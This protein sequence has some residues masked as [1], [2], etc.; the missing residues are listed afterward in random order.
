M[1]R[2]VTQTTQVSRSSIAAFD[3]F[4]TGQVKLFTYSGTFVVPDGITSV[5]ARC[6]GGGGAGYYNGNG[7]AGG[8]SSF[9][10]FCS[11]TGGAGGTNTS[12]WRGLGGTGSGGDINRT[13]GN[14][15]GGSGTTAGGGG[16][17]GLFANGGTGGTAANP[18]PESGNAGGGSSGSL[19]TNAGG[20]GILGKGA[21]GSTTAG[22]SMY[23]TG[24]WIN[25][26]IDFLGCGGG[27]ANGTYGPTNGGGGGGN[28][29]TGANGAWPGGGGA[30]GTT[31]Q[32][33]GGGGG[34]TIETISVT[35]GQS[36]VVTVGAGGTNPGTV[37][38]SNYGAPG[39]VVVE[40]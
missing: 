11:A 23:A 1:G 28:F 14:G 39:C 7:T 29:G 22:D 26:S 40:Y 12:P 37:P 36:I 5:R 3:N 33:G 16:V 15:G 25:L 32:G 27:G 21:I 35:P 4:G 10:A 34:F 8:T 31:S 30:G 18:T 20:N 13:G 17:A 38:I 9:G 6:F 19:T 24:D 2:N